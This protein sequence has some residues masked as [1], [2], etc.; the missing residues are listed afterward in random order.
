[1]PRFSKWT[2]DAS[3]GAYDS[4]RVMLGEQSSAVNE[5]SRLVEHS[6][7][8]QCTLKGEAVGTEDS[9]PAIQSAK[10]IYF[11]LIHRAESPQLVAE[12]QDRQA[13]SL[14]SQPR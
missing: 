9:S 4:G 10:R 2:A 14:G 8:Y 13:D 11:R 3:E 1:M 7:R 5:P 6:V 12:G